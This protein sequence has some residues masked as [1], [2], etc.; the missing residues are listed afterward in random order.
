MIFPYSA[1]FSKQ[2]SP[3]MMMMKM[4]TVN[5]ITTAVLEAALEAALEAVHRVAP[6]AVQKEA[7]VSQEIVPKEA[8]PVVQ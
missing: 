2:F 1:R 4:N 3:K 6:K 5:P 8:Q 7:L